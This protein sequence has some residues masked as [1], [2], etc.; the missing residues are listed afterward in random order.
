MT[1]PSFQPVSEVYAEQT[2]YGQIGPLQVVRLVRSDLS[3]ALTHVVVLG[4][5]SLGPTFIAGFPDT[6]EG[7]GL[8]NQ[9]GQAVVQALWIAATPV[10]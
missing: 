4:H 5:P 1:Q 7:I 10:S 9:V 8:A 2:V 3:L 6:E